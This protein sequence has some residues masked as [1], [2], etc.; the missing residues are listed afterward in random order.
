MAGALRPYAFNLLATLGNALFSPS[1]QS[2]GSDGERPGR[3]AAR[4][5]ASRP[6][7][8]TPASFL[9]PDGRRGR[10]AVSLTFD[11]HPDGRTKRTWKRKPARHSGLHGRGTSRP[12]YGPAGR[13]SNLTTSAPRPRSLIEVALNTA[14]AHGT[15]STAAV[16]GGS[17]AASGTARHRGRLAGLGHVLLDPQARLT[18]PAPPALGP[19]D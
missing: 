9:W 2:D 4:P 5:D 8:E 1:S 6:G 19:R 15:T 16:S 3:R 12:P 18:E 11:V 7:R 17:A 13:P 14:F 10:L